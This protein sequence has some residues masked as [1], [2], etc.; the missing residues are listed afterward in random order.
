MTVEPSATRVPATATEEP[1]GDTAIAEGLRMVRS[2]TRTV[3]SGTPAAREDWEGDISSPA[4]T[5]AGA[6]GVDQSLV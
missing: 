5:P 1:S 6:T 4:V 3:E 2:V